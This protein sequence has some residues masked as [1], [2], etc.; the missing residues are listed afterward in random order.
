MTAPNSDAVRRVL[1]SVH[2]LLAAGHQ[3]RLDA[4]F[5]KPVSPA[6]LPLF[7]FV[8]PA[9]VGEQAVADRALEALLN[10]VIYR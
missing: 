4:S 2:P 8:R 6:P 7:E 9:L 3:I 10:K 5:H 1:E